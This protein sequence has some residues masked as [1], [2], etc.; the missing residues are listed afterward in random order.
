[1]PFAWTAIH[2]VDVINSSGSSDTLDRNSTGNGSNSL[3]K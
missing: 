2:M 1:M 3:G